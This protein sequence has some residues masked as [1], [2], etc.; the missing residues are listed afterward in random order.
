MSAAVQHG[1]RKG[2]KPQIQTLLQMDEEITFDM[3]SPAEPWL[4]WVARLKELA[5][6]KGDATA[7]CDLGVALACGNIAA[8]MP[9]DEESARI[10]FESSAEKGDKGGAFNL[11]NLRLNSG[12]AAGAVAAFEKAANSGCAD[13]QHALG[14]IHYEGAEGVPVNYAKAFRLF[15]M[16]SDRGNVDGLF[17]LAICLANGAGT[18]QDLPTAAE[19]FSQ[20][21]SA[22]HF[23]AQH[24]FALCLRDGLG[25]R[26]NVMA[27]VGL[28]KRSAEG[29][30]V[31]SGEKNHFYFFDS[32]NIYNVDYF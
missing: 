25:M 17:M 30:S 20:C 18:K 21:V 22:G 7:M 13:C 1:R 12:D 11:G 15:K 23:K 28:F 32:K 14:M 8:G 2:E 16:S 10:Y 3:N 19:A 29:G 4:D 26:K 6:V 5:E 24:E 31:P 9:P 27:G